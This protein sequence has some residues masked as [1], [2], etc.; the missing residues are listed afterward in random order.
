MTLRKREDTG[1]GQ[2]KHQI[3]V[4]GERGLEVAMDLSQADYGMST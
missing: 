4:S 3:A 1:I 2:R